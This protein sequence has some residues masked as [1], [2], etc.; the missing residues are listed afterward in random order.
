MSTCRPVPARLKFGR[1]PPPAL[2]ERALDRMRVSVEDPLVLVRLVVAVLLGFGTIVAVTLWIA[3]D[4][5]RFLK[6][7][8][9]LWGVYGFTVGVV[10]GLLTPLV[11]GAARMLQ[12]HGAR[13]RPDFASAEAL[14]AGGHHEL[15]ADKYREMQ[16]GM[17]L[18]AGEDLR[19]GLALVNLYGNQL[20]DPARAMAEL[21]RLVERYAGTRRGVTLSRM[22][23]SRK[24]AQFG[25][26]PPAEDA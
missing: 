19:V 16:A 15:A 6:L 5:A 7:V 12:G 17:S 26:R 9:G 8:I 20:G 18:S 1:L 2:L 21:S 23:A 24:Q 14:V 22:L 11:D 3:A 4:D 13:S 10:D 25:S